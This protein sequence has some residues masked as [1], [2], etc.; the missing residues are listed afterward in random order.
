MQLS[1][2]LQSIIAAERYVP[3]HPGVDGKFNHMNE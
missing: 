3:G 1:V 2:M